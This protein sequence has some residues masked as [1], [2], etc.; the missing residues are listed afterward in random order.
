MAEACSAGDRMIHIVCTGG[1]IS[2][3]P[4][5]GAG[6]YVPVLGADA[7]VALAGGDAAL[8][9]LAVE[10][11]DR[12]PG[13]HMAPE[14]LWALREHV[15]ELAARRDVAGVVI[16]HGT[17]T[18]EETAYVLARTLPR[19][20]APVVLT[21]AM[22]TADAPDWEGARN[23][24]DAVRVARH[25]ASR[26]RGPL[27]VFASRIFAAGFVAK[28]HTTALDAFAAPHGAPLG[29]ADQHGINFVSALPSAAEPLA[30]RR[31]LTPRV[32]LVT[33][34]TGDAGELVDA[35]RASFD[36]LVIEAFGAGNVPPGAVPALERWRG[37]DRPVVLAS[38]CPAGEVS[39]AYGFRGGN[40]AL[41]ALGLIPAGRRTPVQARLELM[42]SLSAGVPYGGR[43]GG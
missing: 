40:A 17:D 20:A 2:M 3:Q 7:L 15:A 19:D 33:L 18:L 25:P 21:G 26:G 38:R 30:P 28:A 35:A 8:G 34:V 41:V 16:T 14:R 10:D 23:L 22:R 27:V 4:D 9:S 12:L 11:W 6:G 32:A 29:T 37:D 43:G 1:T 13:S 5:A 42:L 31:G 36:G 24:R 39:S